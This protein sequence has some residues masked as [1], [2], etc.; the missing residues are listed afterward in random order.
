MFS[1]KLLMFSDNVPALSSAGSAAVANR[2]KQ[3][4]RRFRLPARYMAQLVDYLEATGVD[5]AAVLRTA[6]IRSID[7][8]KAQLT[9]RQV[10]ALLAAA[11]RASG[12]LDLGLELGRRLNPTSHDILGFALITSPT[13][14]DVLRLLVGY[15]RLIQPMF[16]LALE[17][18]GNRVDLVYRPV[19]EL[20]HR[21]M[22]V[23]EETIAA[24]NHFSFARMFDEDL[25]P[26]DLWLSIERPP[27]ADRYRELTAA[28]VHFGDAQ[29]GLRMSVDASLLEKPLVM[30]NP[31]A[32][33]AAEQRCKALLRQTQARRRW[34]EWCRR[35]RREAEDS[36]PTLE[37]L[38]RFVNTSTRTLARY[39]EAEDT[40]F[41]ELSLQ[42]R[43][44]RARQMLADGSRSV[45]QVAYRLG[46][47]DVASFVRSF[48][49]QT[50]QTPG[51]LQ[52]RG[53]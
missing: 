40:S 44:E 50:G 25:P 2:S 35:M 52:R 18:H 3:P 46:Y 42:V 21:A 53:R 19:V 9:Q 36:R 43:T 30:A 37:Q 33:Q 31:R 6:G 10:E 17:R 22:R 47:T 20:T 16:A 15:Q 23:F 5:R 48:R 41:R 28:R 12:R 7:A 13:F 24:S 29:P 1:A 27:H 38:A 14:G 11:E 51:S 32:M 39:L 49:A 34:S 26:Y 45:T 4:A 8:P